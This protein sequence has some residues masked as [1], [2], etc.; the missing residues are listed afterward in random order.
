MGKVTDLI[1]SFFGSFSGTK[2]E[3]NDRVPTVYNYTKRSWGW[4]YEIISVGTG[5]VVRMYGWG[6]GICEGDFL[7]IKSEGG[8]YA[9]IYVNEIS[10]MKDPTDMWN[11]TG[12]ICSS[13]IRDDYDRGKIET[14]NGRGDIRSWG[15]VQI[16][17]EDDLVIIGY[18]EKTNGSLFQRLIAPFR[19]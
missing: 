10:Y 18:P 11:I 2:G 19:A 16:D 6:R 7:L 14:W 1:G 12:Y 3:M 13:A 15:D 9:R 8:E 17:G 5:D 4:N